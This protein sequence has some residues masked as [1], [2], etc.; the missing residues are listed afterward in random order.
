MRLDLETSHHS[1]LID[2]IV[3]LATRMNVELAV[4]VV[5][6]R[7]YGVDTKNK[8]FADVSKASTVS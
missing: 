5:G 2:K 7:S 6:M 3:E 4:Y 8:I 1:I